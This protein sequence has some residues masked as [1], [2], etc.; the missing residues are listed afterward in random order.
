MKT[1]DKLKQLELDNKHNYM[2]LDRCRSDVDYFFG[3]GQIYGHHLYY[4]EISKHMREMINL[5]KS[6]PLK[7]TWLRAAKLIEYKTRVN[8]YLNTNN[9]DNLQKH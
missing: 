2:L 1:Q 9:H 4:G 8:Q 3:N 5:W 6:L 7:P